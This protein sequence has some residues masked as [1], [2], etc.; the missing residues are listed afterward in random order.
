MFHIAFGGPSPLRFRWLN[1]FIVGD[2][3]YWSL[4]SSCY[5]S[6]RRRPS[7]ERPWCIIAFLPPAWAVASISLATGLR[8]KTRPIIATLCA[9]L[10]LAS[11]LIAW[12]TFVD[13]NQVYSDLDALL[14]HM[15]RG[16]AVMAINF[17]PNPPHR[18]WS[19]SVAQGYVV[20]EHG[21]RCVHDY[22]E[23][24][25]SVVAQ[26]PEKQWQ[27]PL[28]RLEGY[29]GGIRPAWDFTRFRYF[30]F[31]TTKP[32][33]ALVVAMALKNDARLIASKGDWYLFES[34]LALAPIDADDAPIPTPHP[35]SLRFL[36]DKLGNDFE[37]LDPDHRESLFPTTRRSELSFSKEHDIRV[38]SR[39]PAPHTRSTHRP[40]KIC[41]TP[42]SVGSAS[43]PPASRS[44]GRRTATPIPVWACT[45]QP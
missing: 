7:R 38:P 13:S 5:I 19:P 42:S 26:R 31:A 21:G 2:S 3:S 37:A 15:Q 40:F 33:V 18:L 23:S 16:A 43:S 20:A 32:S 22:T 1:A 45:R 28:A 41:L 10:P 4:Y 25:V 30:L 36:L 14:P 9:A 24:P 6:S 8:G 39:P 44:A 35:K 17:G 29:L 34:K 12:P 27:E 11:V